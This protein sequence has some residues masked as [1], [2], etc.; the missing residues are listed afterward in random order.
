VAHYVTAQE[1]IVR[2]VGGK[3]SPDRLHLSTSGVL[4]TVQLRLVEIH[5]SVPGNEKDAI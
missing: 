4:I 3:E 2:D 1:V 5:S